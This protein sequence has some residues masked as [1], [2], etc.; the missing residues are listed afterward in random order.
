MFYAKWFIF[1]R[2][3]IWDETKSI[4]LMNNNDK[5]SNKKTDDTIV[6]INDALT[7]NECESITSDLERKCPSCKNILK[8]STIGN[9]NLA[10]RKRNLCRKCTFT[11]RHPSS[12]T[13]ERMSASHLGFKHTDTHRKNMSGQGNGMYGIHRYDTL[14][15]FHGKLHTEEAKRKMRVA[16]CKR[17]LELQRSNDGRVNNV[18]KKE[19]DYFDQMERER[20]WNGV[21][22][23]KSGKQHLIE[24]LGYFVDYY[25]PTLNIVVE[26]DEPRHYQNGILKPRDVKRMEE[27]R[28]YL[29]CQFWRYDEY[30]H[31]L[32]V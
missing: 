20:G 2:R 31:K 5:Q 24:H 4:L 23:K 27:I 11:G 14:N 9:R 21:Y 25:E 1:I 30:S 19:G 18:G 22:Y 26:Y 7:K 13:L 16:A 32:L 12:T 15:P 29:G 6:R 17:V 8:Y 3:V 10:E 28:T